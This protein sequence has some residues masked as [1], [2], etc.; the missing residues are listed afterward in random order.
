[1]FSVKATEFL[2]NQRLEI[3][4]QYY[5]VLT[6]LRVSPNKKFPDGLKVKYVLIDAD[7][8]FARLLIDNHEPFGFHMH[9]QLP[10]DPS[11]REVLSI[12]DYNEALQIFLNE[13]ERIVKL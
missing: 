10:E 2:I 11:V 1:V 5:V 8:G 12:T 6:A 3:N 9:T 7:G 13:V 4:A